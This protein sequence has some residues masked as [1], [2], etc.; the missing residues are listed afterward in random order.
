MNKPFLIAAIMFALISAFG[1]I[2]GSFNDEYDAVAAG[3]LIGLIA[4]ALFHLSWD[5]GRSA[6]QEARRQQGATRDQR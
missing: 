6:S 4:G 3:C 5:L 2:G 1:I